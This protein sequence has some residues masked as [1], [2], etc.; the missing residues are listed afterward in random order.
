MA[1]TLDPGINQYPPV[2]AVDAY[3]REDTVDLFFN[4]MT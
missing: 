2:I 4:T 1:V 3:K